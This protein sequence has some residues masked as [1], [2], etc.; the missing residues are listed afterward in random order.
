MLFC[1]IKIKWVILYC[2]NVL[3][4]YVYGSK[5]CT[6][7]TGQPFILDSSDE[8]CVFTSLLLQVNIGDINRACVYLTFI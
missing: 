1:I 3:S 6:D 4:I 2:N 7:S 5:R 8:T